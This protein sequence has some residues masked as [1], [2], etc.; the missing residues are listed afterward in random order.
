MAQVRIGIYNRL[1]D[2]VQIQYN[3]CSAEPLPIVLP[4]SAGQLTLNMLYF[5]GMIEILILVA[6]RKS[7]NLMSLLTST[8]TMIRATV[9]DKSH[10]HSLIRAYVP[11]E[12]LK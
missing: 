3:R 11:T 12:V 9:H 2:L 10:E 8:S 7:P 4:S 6:D 5:S 1:I